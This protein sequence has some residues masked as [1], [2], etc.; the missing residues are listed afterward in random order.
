[1]PVCQRMGHQSGR[2]EK[3]ITAQRITHRGAFSNDLKP[4]ETALVS[5]LYVR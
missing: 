4:R 1:M 3:F 5:V 2:L